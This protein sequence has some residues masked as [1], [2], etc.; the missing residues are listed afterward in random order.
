MKQKNVAHPFNAINPKVI[1]KQKQIKNH[2]VVKQTL[3]ARKINFFFLF[4]TM[5]F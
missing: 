2:K 4:I 3:K 5:H 1:L